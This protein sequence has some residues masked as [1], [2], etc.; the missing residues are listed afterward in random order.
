MI[1]KSRKS[2][3]LKTYHHGDLRRVL[4]DAALK[5]VGTQGVQGF[6]LREAARVAEV[7]HNAPYRHFDTRT[8]LLV[9]L[10]I[11]GQQLLLKSLQVALQGISNRRARLMAL[12]TAYLEFG[13]SHAAHFRVMYSGEVA[14]NPTEELGTAQSA[15]YEFFEQEIRSGEEEGVFRSGRTTDYALVGWAAIHG[16]TILLLDGLLQGTTVYG[17]HT[18]ADLARLVIESLFD[19]MLKQKK[20]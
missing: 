10:A 8:Q 11:E 15:T 18:P 19:G 6:T 9:A 5:L 17:D 20:N 16:A 3:P 7:S 1:K 14:A 12:G 2:D 4:L 13:C